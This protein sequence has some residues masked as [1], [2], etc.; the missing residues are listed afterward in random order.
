M[1]RVYCFTE[2]IAPTVVCSIW[3]LQSETSQRAIADICRRPG[4]GHGR[5]ICKSNYV[6]IILFG[7]GKS[8]K[9]LIRIVS[10]DYVSAGEAISVLDSMRLRTQVSDVSIILSVF[11]HTSLTLFNYEYASCFRCMDTL[12]VV[13]ESFNCAL[14]VWCLRRIE[15]LQYERVSLFR[16]SWNLNSDCSTVYL[17]PG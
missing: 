13:F 7:S 14:S 8:K 16:L 9:I 4:F 2:T 6:C 1:I 17:S 3:R 10:L 11:K 5:S 12:N 15:R